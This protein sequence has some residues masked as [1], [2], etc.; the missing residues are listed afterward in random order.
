MLCNIKTNPLFFQCF[1]EDRQ[2]VCRCDINTSDSTGIQDHCFRPL[3]LF[4]FCLNIL[5]QDIDICKKEITAEPIDQNSFHC[6]DLTS[7]RKITEMSV[8][9]LDSDKTPCRLRRTDHHF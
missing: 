6:M 2:S 4:Q 5:L 3:F 1:I 9:R 7:L 8:S